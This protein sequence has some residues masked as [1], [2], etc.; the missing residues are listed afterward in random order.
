[1]SQLGIVAI[2]RNEGDRLRRCLSSV[3]GRGFPVVYVDGN[4]TD[5]SVELARSLGA[6]VFVEDPSQR[7]CAAK[8]RNSGFERVCQL[9]PEI[10]F[11]QI[12]DGDCEVVDGWLDRALEVFAAR[13]DVGLVTG[14]RRERH[15]DR[16][17]YNRLADIDWDAPLGEIDGSHGDV[18]VRVEA[19]RQ[20][21][22]CNESMTV[23]EDIDLC[24]RMRQ[25]GWVLLRIPDEMTLH[26]MDMTTFRQWWRRSI[27]NGYGYAQGALMHGRTPRRLF[28]R[29]VFSIL[30]WGLVLPVAIVALALATR[31]LGL[32]VALVYPI[33]M[34]R[35][36]AR[37]YRS[38]MT[39]RVAW[40]YGWSCVVG[41][42]ANAIGLV[43]FWIERLRGQNRIERVITYK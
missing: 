38:G 11:V 41:K 30:F 10:R 34:L 32:I 36:A 17:P 15:P 22:G 28:V 27:R 35:I 20:I 4:S 13:P 8:A 39:A 37:H 9:D 25:A 31:G 6:E 2:G 19:Y 3:C 23:S 24:V 42:F 29:D 7:N 18:M 16:S 43:R 26:D 14:R 1:M 21:G 12:I 5:G 40:L 33:Q